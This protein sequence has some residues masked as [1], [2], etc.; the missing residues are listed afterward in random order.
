MK[1]NAYTT[2]RTMAYTSHII[3]FVLI[4]EIVQHGAKEQN[5]LS[6]TDFVFINY[7]NLGRLTC[8]GVSSL[9]CVMTK[10]IN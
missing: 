4:F 8:Q 5:L 7:L 6:Q 9:A 1:I 3:I 2:L 10:I